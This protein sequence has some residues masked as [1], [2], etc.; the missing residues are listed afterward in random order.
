MA[1]AGPPVITKLILPKQEWSMDHVLY[2]QELRD[3]SKV[4]AQKFKNFHDAYRGKQMKIRIP[5]IIISTLAGVSSFG[6]STYPQTAQSIVP[7]VVGCLNVFVAIIGSIESFLKL[8]EIIVSSLNASV[9]F[10]K[11]SEKIDMELSVPEDERETSGINTVR[12]CFQEYDSIMNETTITV[13][14]N[15]KWVKPFVK[16][17][18]NSLNSMMVTPTARPSSERRITEDN[19]TG[20]IKITINDIPTPPGMRTHVFR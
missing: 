5:T 2:L 18:L 13:M 20:A 9:L 3:S 11:L 17:S 7:I 1:T 19:E 10:M 16:Q 14:H 6:V 12:N 8:N 15:L 4:L